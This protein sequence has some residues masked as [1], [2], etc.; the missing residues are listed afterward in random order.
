MNSVVFGNLSVSLTD[1]HGARLT[2]LPLRAPGPGPMRRPYGPTLPAPPFMVGRAGQRELVRRAVRERGAV[3]FRGPCGAGKTTLLRNAG[4]G[5]V[6]VGRTELEDLLQDLMR[7]FYVYPGA[8]GVRL[9]TDECAGALGQVPGGVV[10]LDDVSYNPQQLG[11]LRAVLRDCALVVGAATPVL[12]TLGTSQAL[13]GLSEQEALALLAHELGRAVADAERDA[14]RRLVAAVGGQPLSLRQA[15]ALVRVDGRSFAELATRAESGPG[16]L[17]ELCISAVGPQAKRVLGVLTLLGGALLPGPVLAQMADIAYV[18][19]TLESLTARGLAEQAEDRFGLPV[20]KSDSYRQILYHYI[21]L[22]SVLRSLGAWLA[23]CD[24]GGEEA[25]GAVD[26]ALSLLGIAAE[27]RQWQ[28]VVQLVTVVERVLFVQGH[29]QSW[30]N[31]L[32]QGITAAQAAGNKAAEAYFTH[33][34]GVQHFLHDRVDHAHRLLRRALDLRTQLGDMAGAA[35]TRANLA[36]LE[37]PPPPPMPSTPPSSGTSNSR[38]LVMAAVAGVVAVLV[39]GSAIVQAVGGGGGGDDDGGSASPLVS[40]ADSAGTEGS[41]GQVGGGTTVGGAGGSPV[42]GGTT[43]GRTTGGV[44]TSGGTTEG[45]TSTGTSGGPPSVPLDGPVITASEPDFGTVNITTGLDTSVVTFSIANPND[46][47][48]DIGPTNIVDGSVFAS[49]RST[50][51]DRLEAGASCTEDIEFGP[52][53]L[54][55]TSTEFTVSS[56]SKTSRAPLT[57]TGVVSLTIVLTGGRD[58]AELAAKDAQGGELCRGPNPTTCEIDVSTPGL[59]LTGTITGTGFRLKRWDG[60]CVGGN[61]CVPVLDQDR[62]VTAT[63]APDIR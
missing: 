15:A 2:R 53:Q 39:V 5:Y 35:V 12:G 4:G 22:A 44:P 9:T 55:A 59:E 51:G 48:I 40:S 24:P 13:P 32:A 45:R 8:E 7:Q 21:G 16:V 60:D 28:A 61:P 36:L 63:F 31:T 62:K 43:G 10:A 11:Y 3:E 42:S 34:Q 52:T 54:G 6:R 19:E 29:W 23:S 56:G 47:A 25:R 33:Q 17:D 57:G 26:A 14:V 41:G 38:R 46:Q 18:A 1:R 37:P 30:Q 50:C 58:T 49:V 20:C 27:R